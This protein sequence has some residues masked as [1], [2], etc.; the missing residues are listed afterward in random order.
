MVTS[1]GKLLKILDQIAP[2]D[3]ADVWDNSGLLIGNPDREVDRVLL[4]LDLT[5]E[6]MNEAIDEG[7]DLVVTHHP[8]IFNPLKKITTETQTGKLVMKLIENK[9]ALVAMHTNLDRS[10]SQGINRFVGDALELNQIKVLEGE[11]QIGYGVV[12]NLAK[13]KTLLEMA[14]N[15]KS[16][17]N[18]ETLKVTNG[19]LDKVISRIAFCSGASADFIQQAL[20]EH[21]DLYI[22][23]DLKHHE[24]QMVNGTK[25][26]LIDVGHYE[27]EAVYL[28][29]L[30]SLM[31][32][33]IIDKN[34]DVFTKVTETEVPQFKYI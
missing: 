25:M 17:F 16:L 20:S 22:T 6:V 19:D 13:S 27:S 7:F 28:E 32:D 1:L 14:Q 2:F 24:S 30:K 21:A 15:L 5:E 11:D 31:D 18:Q 9:I 8:L 10:F 29:R 3:S 33:L 12:G 23:S 34:Y 26:T 4:A